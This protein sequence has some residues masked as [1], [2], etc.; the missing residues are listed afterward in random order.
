[1]LTD[2]RHAL[3]MARTSV[4][5]ACM[6]PFPPSLYA[7]TARPAPETPPLAGDT[8]AAV[9]IVGAGIAGL[10]TALHLAER[11]VRAVVLDANGPGWGASGRNG[12][13][14]NPGLKEE[15]SAVLA[16]F[17][18]DGGSRLLDFAYG[19]PDTTFDLIRRHQIQCEARQGGTL[20]AARTPALAAKVRR[21]A[22]ECA[23]RGMPVRLL[24]GADAAAATGGEGYVCAMLDPRGGD[25]HPLDYARGLARAAVNAG[26]VVHGGSAVRSLTPDGGGWRLRTDGGSVLADQVV[27][28]TNGYTDGLWPGLKQ[29]VVPVFSSIVASAPLDEAARASILPGRSVLW[30]NGRVTV[31]CR[32][33]AAGRMVL[34][35]RGPQRDLGGPGGLKYLV[36]LGERRWPALRGAR[37]EHGWNGQLAMTPDHYPHLHEL[38]PGVLAY[39]GCNGRGVALATAMGGELARRLAGEDCVL[40]ATPPAPMPLH[41][42]WRV[43][44]AAAVMKGR[45]MD[46]LGL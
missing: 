6:R 22:E 24:E 13:H 30:E 32:I 29:T 14:V 23:A 46:S 31:Y 34:G 12:G 4:H 36:A 41:R 16:R 38:A 1:M 33:D 37:W 17:G 21:A 44:V 42:F 15:P 7:A 40:P 18:A 19:A 27:L 10:S 45:V 43:G 35:G 8:R 28:A 11:G 5:D 2:K 9:A 39:L 3:N 26:A 25:I 20:R